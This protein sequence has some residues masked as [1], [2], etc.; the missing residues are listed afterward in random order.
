MCELGQ[1]QEVQ[2]VVS[3]KIQGAIQRRNGNGNRRRRGSHSS[4][5]RRRN[6]T[7]VRK[8][9]Q[10]SQRQMETAV[11]GGRLGCVVSST[12]PIGEEEW[13]EMHKKLKDVCKTIGVKEA[14][15]RVAGL[16]K[17]VWRK[18]QEIA[19]LS[20]TGEQ[21]QAFGRWSALRESLLSLWQVNINQALRLCEG[22][23]AHL[24]TDWMIRGR[25][26]SCV[27]LSECFFFFLKIF[28]RFNQPFAFAC[29]F[30]FKTAVSS[31]RASRF[32]RVC[33]SLLLLQ[34]AF[35][36]PAL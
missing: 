16:S 8:H 25:K 31:L 24:S 13:L 19:L 1:Y 14:G 12:V 27:S 32:Q 4:P 22:R 23:Q 6:T 18:T 29:F 21:V 10:D 33:M 7:N 11:D 28:C 26:K 17:V 34:F 15:Q 9:T 20:V 30:L 3:P 36:R 2:E 5:R 35:L